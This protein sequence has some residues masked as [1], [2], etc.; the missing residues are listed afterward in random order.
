VKLWIEEPLK[1]ELAGLAE[2]LMNNS[3]CVTAAFQRHSEAAAQ[4]VAQH[5]ARDFFFPIRN[6]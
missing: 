4:K 5:P 3:K 1:L 6:E 2:T